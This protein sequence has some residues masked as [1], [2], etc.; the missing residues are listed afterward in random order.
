MMKYQPFCLFFHWRL[1]DLPSKRIVSKIL[2]FEGVLE[3]NRF[4]LVFEFPS[5][6]NIDVFNWKS[7]SPKTKGVEETKNISS[8]NI[9][10]NLFFKEKLLFNVNTI[11][12]QFLYYSHFD[13]FSMVLTQLDYF[14]NKFVGYVNRWHSIAFLI[15]LSRWT[16]RHRLLLLP[17][18][19]YQSASSCLTYYYSNKIYKSSMVSI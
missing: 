4:M 19:N 3:T 2:R 11:S 18:A 16:Q 14:K 7:S 10:D 8:T 9:T 1:I 12:F 5:T 6:G 17:E 13:V 15:W